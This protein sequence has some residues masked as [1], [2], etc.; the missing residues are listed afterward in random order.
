MDEDCSSVRR[1]VFAP[2]WCGDQRPRPVW[3]WCRGVR[4]SGV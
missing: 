4:I 1:I 3:S 2:V